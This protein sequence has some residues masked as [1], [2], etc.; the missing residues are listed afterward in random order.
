MENVLV[1]GSK[2]ESNLPDIKVSKIYTANGAAERAN[3]FRKKYSE[4]ELTCIVGAREF[5]RNEQ[6]SRRIIEA[7]PEKF[8]IRSGAIDLPIEL[9]DYSKLILLSN[10]EQWNF[11]S[12][13]FKYKKLS[14]FFSEIFHQSKLIDKLIHFLKFIKNKNIWGVSTGFYAILLALDEN[15]NS[16]IIISGI[17]MKGG[18]QFYKSERSNYYVYDSRARVDKFLINRL[19][20]NYKDRLCTLDQELAEISG[21]SLWKG[22]LL[23]LQ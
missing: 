20:K 3:Y 18:K 4:N 6:V 22:D 14:L 15:P 11:Q 1:L 16:K 13:F 5:A 23:Q 9:K 8:F 19:F 12:K 10:D 17:G 21:I 2:P 7:K